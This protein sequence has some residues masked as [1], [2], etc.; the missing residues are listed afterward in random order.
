MMS[1]SLLNKIKLAAAGGALAI[2]IALLGGVEGRKYFPYYDVAG[3]L[4]V[5]DGHTGKDIVPGKRYSDAECESLLQMDLA[6]VKRTVDSAVTVPIGDYTRAAL[7]SFTYNVGRTAFINST[8]LK[9]LNS[10]D[11]AGACN[12][13]RRWVN[14]AGKKWRGLVNRREIDREVCLM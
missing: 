6:P 12:E 1:S 2:A 8:L 3:V 10:G 7:Y 4:T 5:C 13:L 11:T 14:A 9:K